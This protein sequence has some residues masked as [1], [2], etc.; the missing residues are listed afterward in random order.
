MK[1]IGRKP[2]IVAE[3]D[4]ER[5]PSPALRLSVVVPAHDMSRDLPHC[6]AA[7]EASDLPRD[8]WELIVID[9]SLGRGPAFAR[10]RGIEKANSSVVAFVDADVMV[11][12]DALR[13][14]LNHFEDESVTAVFG[15]YDTSPLAPGIVSQYRNLLHAYV[16]QHAPGDVESFWAG[17]GAAR[18]QSLIAIG[19][20]DEKRFT[21][22]EMED[23]EL[24]YRMRD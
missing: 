10:N 21:R 18:K 1:D 2:D 16:H 3:R 15:S 22:P 19:M 9:D 4:L 20:F 11:H 17:C 24:G 12:H 7:L 14:L 5:D 13:I 23:V 6:I 8:S